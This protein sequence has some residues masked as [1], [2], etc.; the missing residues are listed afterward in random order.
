MRVEDEN[1]NRNK[2]ARRT[3]RVARKERTRTNGTKAK[4]ILQTAVGV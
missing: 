1:K 2:V 3:D 4:G